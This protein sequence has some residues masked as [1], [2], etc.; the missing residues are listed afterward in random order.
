[1]NFQRR[2]NFA[3]VAVCALTITV[4]ASASLAAR[5]KSSSAKPTPSPS[6][7]PTPQLIEVTGSILGVSL[8]SSLE[9]AREK[10]ERFKLEQEPAKETGEKEER[11]AGER[12]IWRLAE[13]EYLWIVAWANK[14]GKVVKISASVRPEKQKPFREI[15]DLSRAKTHNDSMALWVVQHA[16]GTYYR[17]VAKGPAEKASSVYLYSLKTEVFQ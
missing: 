13:T 4:A 6:P 3:R 11:E 14:E 16:N 5:K 17:V 15:G 1:M 9:D 12:V 7:S 8:F 10:M 2:M